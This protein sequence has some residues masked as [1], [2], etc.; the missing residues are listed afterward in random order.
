LG[1]H[2]QPRHQAPPGGCIV[3]LDGFQQPIDAIADF[4]LLAGRLQVHIRR[5]AA[6]R[7]VEDLIDER[8]RIH[9]NRFNR[10]GGRCLHY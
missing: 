5:A 6:N 4:Q 8:A 3:L 2:H 10:D 9:K 1:H 7:F